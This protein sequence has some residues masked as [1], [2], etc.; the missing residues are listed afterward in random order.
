MAAAAAKKPA[1]KRMPR[2]A[3]DFV[4]PYL[5]RTEVGLLLVAVGAL[6]ATGQESELLDPSVESA[7]R[8]L[9]RWV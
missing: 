8:E 2:R 4:R 6:D 5:T 1:T 7:V 3:P 9:K